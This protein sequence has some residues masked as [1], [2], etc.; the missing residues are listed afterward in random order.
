M[1]NMFIPYPNQSIEDKKSSIKSHLTFIRF[2]KRTRP[3]PLTDEQYKIEYSAAQDSIT[4]E[5]ISCY[6]DMSEKV[7]EFIKSELERTRT[8]DLFNVNEAL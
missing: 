1:I 2:L 7:R 6:L 3:K 8:S 4:E 5:E